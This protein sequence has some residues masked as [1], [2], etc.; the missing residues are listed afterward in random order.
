MIKRLRFALAR[1]LDPDG[2]ID[3]YIKK[4]RAQETTILSL[5]NRD[6]SRVAAATEIC[7]DFRIKDEAGELIETEAQFIAYAERRQKAIS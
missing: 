6:A 4:Q 3:W 2:S 1:A 5:L 7:Q